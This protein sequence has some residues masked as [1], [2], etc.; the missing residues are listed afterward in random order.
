A[1]FNDP[2]HAQ[3]QLEDVILSAPR[4]SEAYEARELLTY[5]HWRRGDFRNARLQLEQMLAMK[6]DADDVKKFLA[7]FTVLSG[8]PQQKVERRRFS[9]IPSSTQDA[10]RGPV[11]INGIQ[12]NFLFD[13]GANFPIM[14]ASEA[15][16]LRMRIR[17][18]AGGTLGDGR[19]P[20]SLT[21]GDVA[22]ADQVTI[23][24]T[25]ISNVA[26]L[27]LPDERFTDTPEQQRGVIGLP[28]L[29]TLRT[30]RW[31]R[32]EA[33]EFAFPSER[34][35]PYK[36]N[37]CFDSASPVVAV[38]AGQSRLSFS[39][40]TGATRTDLYAR[41]GREF[42]QLV[43]TGRKDT[44]LRTGAGGTVRDDVVVLPD[45]QIQLGGLSTVLRSANVFP[46]ENSSWHGNL[47]MDLLKQARVVTI[48]FGAMR[49]TL[50]Q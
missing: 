7:L 32:G 49:L 8:F 40:D 50:S 34:R 26:F 9:R 17:R 35:D 5:L 29:L 45:V 48:D 2:E 16:K 22:L 33:L 20:Y 41:F 44:A 13:T 37:L 18:G 15:V 30:I 27:V 47:G 25:T 12:R 19:G 43:E 31:V 3:K 23:G 39:F 1:A 4:P 42:R 24:D 14:S 21:V 6:P 28:V 10:L 36:A 38:H 46:N 11:M